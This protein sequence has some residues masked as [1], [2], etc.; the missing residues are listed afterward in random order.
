MIFAKQ[1]KGVNQMKGKIVKYVAVMAFSV[2]S[3]IWGVCDGVKATKKFV[4]ELNENKEENNQE[5]N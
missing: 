4:G 5:E 1:K 3:V 2:I